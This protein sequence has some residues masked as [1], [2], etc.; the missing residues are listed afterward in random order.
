MGKYM[1]AYR[2]MTVNHLPNFCS[3]NPNQKA[4][5]E[6]QEARINTC[7]KNLLAAQIR[8]VQTEALHH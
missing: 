4:V 7:D 3:K 8:H 1:C 6:V 5:L 2:D